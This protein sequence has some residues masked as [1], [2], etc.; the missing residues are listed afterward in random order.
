VP[1]KSLDFANISNLENLTREDL[2]SPVAAAATSQVKLCPFDEEEQH[3]WFCLIEAQFA[4]AG[5]K[6]QKLK[7]ANILASL[8]KQVLRDI[9]DTLDVCNDSDEPLDFLKN[10]LLQQF[11]KGKWQSYFELLRLPME[12]QGLKPSVLMGKLKQHL[13]PGVSPDNDLFL[14]MFLIRLPPSMR[15]IVGAGTH[16]TAADALWDAQGGHDATVAAASTQRSRSPAPS[17]GK[18]SVKR[19]GNARPKSRPLPAQIFILLKTLAVACANFPTTMPI[20]LTGAFQMHSALFLVG[21]LI[22]RRTPFGSAVF[23]HILL[24]WLCIFL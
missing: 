20:G 21:K 24:P 2:T 18:R 19:D 22:R 16:G 9:L 6:L 11:G 4:A 8:P 5:I 10:T 3:I 23:P 13:P 7:Y 1:N 12:M 14:A 15:E 17:N